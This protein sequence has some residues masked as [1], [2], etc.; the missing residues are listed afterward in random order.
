[1][2]AQTQPITK[3]YDPLPRVTEYEKSRIAAEPKTPPTD[4]QQKD[5]TDILSSPIV[6]ELIIIIA[7]I[8]PF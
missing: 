7:I 1:M 8:Y 2:A 3:T 5:K 4:T 6:A